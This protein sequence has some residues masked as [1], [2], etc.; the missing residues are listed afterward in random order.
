MLRETSPLYRF[1]QTTSSKKVSPTTKM[2]KNNITLI[3]QKSSAPSKKC[4]KIICCF[5]KSSQPI[6]STHGPVPGLLRRGK[7]PFQRPPLPLLPRQRGPVLAAFGGG[8]AL[9]VQ[10]VGYKG[11]EPKPKWSG[12]L[13]TIS[14]HKL[15]LFIESWTNS[16]VVDI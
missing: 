13:N 1:I 4:K 10:L 8:T 9:E 15:W 5:P 7:S 3:F 14:L 2:A 6:C 16:D 11:L 12:K